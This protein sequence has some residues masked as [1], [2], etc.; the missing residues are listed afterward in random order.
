MILYRLFLVWGTNQDCLLFDFESLISGIDTLP[1]TKRKV[2][3]ILAKIFDPTGHLNPFVVT[4]KLL[5]QDACKLKLGWDMEL[6]VKDQKLWT[7]WIKD[8]RVLNTYTISRSYFTT[9]QSTADITYDIHLFCDASSRAYGACAYL[10]SP[11]LGLCRS[12]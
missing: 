3:C 12:V 10:F 11:V 4:A 8:L 7:K 6:P 9:F 1:F 5:F 2:L